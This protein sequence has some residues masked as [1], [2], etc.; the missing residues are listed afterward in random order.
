MGYDADNR[1]KLPGHQRSRRPGMVM[2]VPLLEQRKQLE[3][4]TSGIGCADGFSY[5]INHADALL[6]LIAFWTIVL[7]DWRVRRHHQQPAP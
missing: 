1:K 2:T 4:E 3:Q 7:L 5:P 6:W